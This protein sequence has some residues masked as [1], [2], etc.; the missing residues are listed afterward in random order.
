MIIVKPR[1]T[2]PSRRPRTPRRGR[3][4]PREADGEALD[5]QAATVRI[6]V[7]AEGRVESASIESDPGLGFGRAALECARAM[8]YAPALDRDGRPT[9]ASASI[10]VRFWR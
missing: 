3:C 2:R 10:R 1:C 8:Q 7:S 4:S 6:T 5:T 9:R